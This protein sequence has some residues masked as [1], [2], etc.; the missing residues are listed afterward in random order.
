MWLGQWGHWRHVCGGRATGGVPSP[1]FP[2][3]DTYR[4]SVFNPRW[5]RHRGQLGSARPGNKGR[6]AT[7]DV[8]AVF[9]V[10][11]PVSL[12]VMNR[13][14]YAVYARRWPRRGWPRRGW[15]SI[16]AK[17]IRPDDCSPASSPIATRQVYVVNAGGLQD[18][19]PEYYASFLCFGRNRVRY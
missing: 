8:R 19:N 17:S 12:E 11:A 5:F 7:S 18:A 3:A 14:R 16:R 6:D 10:S 1:D 13:L 2:K 4:R 9:F 15:T